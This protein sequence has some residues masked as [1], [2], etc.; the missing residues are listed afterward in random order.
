MK[1]ISTKMNKNR[2][3]ITTAVL[4]KIEHRSCSMSASC[5]SVPG[6]IKHGTKLTGR[7]PYLI[8]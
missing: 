5:C 2:S 4:K 6:K 3:E 8:Q 1:D 7:K